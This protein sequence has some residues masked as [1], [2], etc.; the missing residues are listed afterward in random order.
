GQGLAGAREVLDRHGCGNAVLKQEVDR[1]DL[2]SLERGLHDTLDVLGPTVETMPLP[3]GIDVEPELRC[4][5]Y[6]SAGRREGLTHELLV[7]KWAVGLGS[8][9]E[10]DAALDGRPDDPDPLLPVGRRAV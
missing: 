2:E 1:L 6:L 8:V 9:E 10:R 3:V 7:R 4:D 5:H